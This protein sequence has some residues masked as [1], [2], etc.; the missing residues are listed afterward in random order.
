MNVQSGS[1]NHQFR[2]WHGTLALIKRVDT[3]HRL[4]LY[5]SLESVRGHTR[6]PCVADPRIG[7]R[8]QDACIESCQEWFIAV[9]IGY[10]LCVSDVSNH[11]SLQVL[12]E[13]AKRLSDESRLQFLEANKLYMLDSMEVCMLTF[14]GVCANREIL[15]SSSLIPAWQMNIDLCLHICSPN[16]ASHVQP[17]FQ[18][19]VNAARDALLDLFSSPESLLGCIQEINYPT[20][21]QL[22][23]AR[24]VGLTQFKLYFSYL[25]LSRERKTEVGS[26]FLVIA[27]LPAHPVHLLF[28]AQH[29]IAC[30]LG[31]CAAS[32]V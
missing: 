21:N 17:S 16:C 25:L 18:S 3:P 30:R 22:F 8:L 32:T 12:G 6:F 1:D 13:S 26:T 27:F 5:A 20:Q 10:H 28:L 7:Q 24:V 14:H 4:E 15:S 23:L 9:S 19:L 2:R 11:P 31:K 29:N